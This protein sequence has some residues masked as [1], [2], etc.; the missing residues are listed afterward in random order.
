MSKIYYY[1]RKAALRL[2][3]LRRWSILLYSPRK[4]DLLDIN[5]PG[6][7][8]VIERA[9]INQSNLIASN[10]P[11][12]VIGYMPD[13]EKFE[14]IHQLFKNEIPCYLAMDQGTL[15]GGCWFKRCH[16]PGIIALLPHPDIPTYEISMLFITTKKRGQGLGRHLI[17]KAC[18]IMEKDNCT[19][20]ISLIWHSRKASISAHINAGFIPMGEKVTVSVGGLR[21]SYIR[22]NNNSKQENQ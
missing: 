13:K 15:L 21:W 6:I 19:Q 5:N 10:I 9:S 16:D 22:S 4:Q 8:P 12:E 17:L 20:I 2:C 7:S 14:Y 11:G 1:S 3:S 18:E